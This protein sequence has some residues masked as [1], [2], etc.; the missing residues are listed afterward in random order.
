MSGN[1]TSILFCSSGS[2]SETEK[3]LRMTF[4]RAGFT[5]NGN[6]DWDKDLKDSCCSVHF[7]GQ[8]TSPAGESKPGS[9]EIFGKITGSQDK[10]E[11]YK[12]FFWIPPQ[13]DLLALEP[14]QR[15]FIHHLQNNL[16]DAMILSRVPSAVQFVDDVRSIL[17]ERPG[18]SYDVSPVDIFLICNQ[19]DDKEGERIKIML[20]DVA[21]IIKLVI[22]PDSDLDYEAY[23]A[24]QM[25]LSKLS[26]IYY[27]QGADWAIPF[28]QQIWKKVGGAS[29]KSPILVIGDAGTPSNQGKLF[30]APRVSSM[31]LSIE[32][33]P[34]EIKVQFDTFNQTE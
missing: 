24:Q 17:E 7:I 33:I 30:E 11:K 25:N 1:S 28:A 34:L 5:L 2:D 20:S 8:G 23:T 15:A 4:S 13:Q 9:E 22:V 27:N 32:L 21:K 29:A 14:S 10:D 6:N 19:A 16:S 31:I 26:V 12:S 18:K 3:G